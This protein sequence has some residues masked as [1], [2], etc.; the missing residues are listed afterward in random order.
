MVLSVTVMVLG[1]DGDGAVTFDGQ[2][3]DGH[4]EDKV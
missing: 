2:G 1:S 3:V 4:V